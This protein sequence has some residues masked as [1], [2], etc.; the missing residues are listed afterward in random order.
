MKALSIKLRARLKSRPCDC[1]IERVGQQCQTVE[2][3]HKHSSS[4]MDVSCF[5]PTKGNIRRPKWENAMKPT[6]LDTFRFYNNGASLAPKQNP[7]TEKMPSLKTPQERHLPNASPGWP[8]FPTWWP[9]GGYPAPDSELLYTHH[10][11]QVGYDKKTMTCSK[12]NMI[13]LMVQKSCTTWDV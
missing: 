11:L 10:L 9:T 1:W 5:A 2:D 12:L 6:T 7:S 3:P 4:I 8:C 13:L